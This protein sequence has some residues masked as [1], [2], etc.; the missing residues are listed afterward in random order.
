[1]RGI[2]GIFKNSFRDF[3]VGWGEGR[4]KSNKGSGKRAKNPERGYR[5]RMGNGRKKEEN[6]W[7][8]W[9]D[10]SDEITET[11]ATKRYFVYRDER[12]WI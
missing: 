8:S 5:R 9:Q 12:M 1:M 2:R 4:S 10:E 3:F 7:K 11:E 6:W